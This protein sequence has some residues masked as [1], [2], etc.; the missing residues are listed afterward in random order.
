MRPANIDSG[1]ASMTHHGNYQYVLGGDLHTKLPFSIQNFP[2]LPAGNL[3]DGSGDLESLLAAHGGGDP[4]IT[5]GR[6][7][8]LAFGKSLELMD[9][10]SLAA[11]G[12]RENG[13]GIVR[14]QSG[15]ESMQSIEDAL[16]DSQQN[17]QSVHDAIDAAVA[18]VNRTSMRQTLAGSKRNKLQ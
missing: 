12:R 5:G 8:S 14:N 2:S 4:V 9:G 15:L 3:P 17:T 11:A 6:F 16:A 18:A 13:G 7:P 10:T 1:T